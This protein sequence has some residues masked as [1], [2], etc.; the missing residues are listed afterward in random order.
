MED[1]FSFYFEEK[2]VSLFL[3]FEKKDKEHGLIDLEEAKN[4]IEQEIFECIKNGEKGGSV[5]FVF[6]EVC[7]SGN[8]NFE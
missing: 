4:F 2:K 6:N 8:W 5:E 1:I 3:V 7:Y